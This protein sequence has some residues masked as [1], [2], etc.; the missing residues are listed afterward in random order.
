M[1]HDIWS[2]STGSNVNSG[3]AK[4][5]KNQNRKRDWQK[6]ANQLGVDA[7]SVDKSKYDNVVSSND[8][9]GGIN[10][11]NLRYDNST[12]TI[13][14]T[15]MNRTDISEIENL[16][17][18]SNQAV[19]SDGSIDTSKGYNSVNASTNTT[20]Y[21][22]N[23]LSGPDDSV[24]VIERG[25]DISTR[26][27]RQLLLSNRL[28]A[29]YQA[30]AI[31]SSLAKMQARNEVFQ[32][33]LINLQVK[34]FN[35]MN[36]ELKKANSFRISVQAKYYQ[37]S[38][39]TQNK[40]LSEVQT[41]NQL[42]RVGL[43]IKN[44]QR[45]DSAMKESLAQL[46][47]G[48][49]W[50]KYTK[51]G[52]VSA[53]KNMIDETGGPL[54]SSTLEMIRGM[55]GSVVGNLSGAGMAK[56]G[57]KYAVKSGLGFLFGSENAEKITQAFTNVGDT[58]EA[59]AEKWKD[60]GNILLRS[61]GK[62]FGS[63]EN[64]MA[65]FSS[66]A[67]YKNKGKTYKEKANFDQAAHEALTKVIPAQLSELL[68]A[69]TKRPA[70]Y[71]NYQTRDWTTREDFAKKI[72]KD[73]L[74]TVMKKASTKIEE[75]L[76]EMQ[77][78]EDEEIKNYF[79]NLK[80]MCTVNGKLNKNTYELVLRSARRYLERI[81]SK[82]RN[83]E[84]MNAVSLA[85]PTPQNVRRVLFGER[86]A[87]NNQMMDPSIA[88]QV[89]KLVYLMMNNPSEIS[90]EITEELKMVLSETAQEVK[91]VIKNQQEFVDSSVASVTMM[92]ARKKDN[93]V[94]TGHLFSGYGK[95]KQSSPGAEIDMI[96]KA[97]ASGGYS[98]ALS[99]AIKQLEKQKV[100]IDPD[101]RLMATASADPRIFLGMTKGTI[102]MHLDRAKRN[103]AR[104][105]KEMYDDDGAANYFYTA[106]EDGIAK[107]EELLK[108]NKFDDLK[109]LSEDDRNDMLRKL[110]GEKGDASNNYAKFDSLDPKDIKRNMDYMMSTKSGQQKAKVLTTAGIAGLTGVLAHKFAGFGPVGSTLAGATLASVALFKGD[111]DDKLAVLTTR[112]G[113]ELVDDG[114]GRT[115]REVLMQNLVR[116]ALPMGVA[117][118]AGIKTS[119]FIKANVRFGP[120][121]G[122]IMGFTVGSAVYGLSKLGFLKKIIGFVTKPFAKLG[123]IIDKK[124]FGGAVG[125]MMKPVTTF[126]KDKLGIGDN[127]KRYSNKELTQGAAE[128]ARANVGTL[129]EKDAKA[130]NSAID[131][132]SKCKSASEAEAWL[133]SHFPKGNIKNISTAVAMDMRVAGSTFRIP[134]EYQKRIIDIFT[135]N[136]W[137]GS[138]ASPRKLSVNGQVAGD[139]VPSVLAK[140]LET[141]FGQK[142][143]P[144]L[145]Y[146]SASAFITNGGVSSTFISSAL[147]NIPGFSVST[148]SLRNIDYFRTKEAF[149]VAN[150]GHKSENH[151]VLFY[152][153]NGKSIKCFDPM[154]QSS[155]MTM[156]IAVAMVKAKSGM[157]ITFNKSASK[158]TIIKQGAEA[159]TR[160][161][162]G[163]APESNMDIV[164]NARVSAARRLSPTGRLTSQQQERPLQVEVVTGNLESL[165]VVGAIDVEAY[166]AVNRENAK[167]GNKLISKFGQS[168]AKM[169]QT[170][171]KK[172]GRGKK[173]DKEQDVQMKREAMNTANLN[174]LANPK[175][176][177]EEKHG[178]GIFGK[179]LPL[180]AMLGPFLMKWFKGGP[181]WIFKVGLKNLLK[182][183]I[184]AGK[185]IGGG[186]KKLFKGVKSK[187]FGDASA[188]A[189]ESAAKNAGKEVAEEG[190]EEA[191]ENATKKSSKFVVN[192]VMKKTSKGAFEA[193]AYDK[194]KKAG[195]EELG[196]KGRI[197][198]SDYQNLTTLANKNS[199]SVARKAE[200]V[201][202]NSKNKKAAGE[203]FKKLT[204]QA[205]SN[206]VNEVI[207]NSADDVA[208]AAAEGATKEVSQEAAEETMKGVVTQTDNLL[209]K[210]MKK[211]L[212]KLEKLPFVG[213]FVKGIAGEVADTV[214]D[215]LI[216]STAEV[217]KEGAEAGAKAGAGT[218]K[219]ALAGVFGVGTVVNIAF[220]AWDIISAIN[221]VPKTFQLAKGQKPKSGMK[222]AAGVV[223]G[224]LSLVEAIVPFAGWALIPVRVFLQDKIIRV[225]YDKFFKPNPDKDGDGINDYTGE[226]IDP[227]NATD[228]EK[229][230]QKENMERMKKRKERLRP[231]I[232]KICG[233]ITGVVHGVLSIPLI[234]GALKLLK[235]IGLDI[236]AVAEGIAKI[237]RDE[238]DKAA[239]A[240]IDNYLEDNS[241][242]ES[243][244]LSAQKGRMALGKRLMRGAKEITAAVFAPATAI[245]AA[246]KGYNQAAPIIFKNE[247]PKFLER[248]SAGWFYAFYSQLK[249]ML[250]FPTGSAGGAT[251]AP[252]MDLIRILVEEKCVK[253]IYSIISALWNGVSSNVDAIT[254]EIKDLA[255]ASD[256]DIA[257]SERIK[258]RKKRRADQFKK[259]A[260]A[261]KNAMVKFRDNIYKIPIIGPL[262]KAW[263][264]KLDIQKVC[265]EL[266]ALT[267][268][269]LEEIKPEDIDS[270]L[271]ANGS[272]DEVEAILFGSGGGT[273]TKKGG[274]TEF[275]KKTGEVAKKAAGQIWNTI[276]LDIFK[277]NKLLPYVYGDKGAEN[278]TFG[279][280]FALWLVHMFLNFSSSALRLGGQDGEMLA[281]TF[282]LIFLKPFTIYIYNKFFAA[283][284][285]I[286][287]NGNLKQD[288]EDLS[289]KAMKEKKQE[290]KK[291][292]K[293]SKDKKGGQGTKGDTKDAA[294]NDQTN[295]MTSQVGERAKA[296]MSAL[297]LDSKIFGG[298]VLLDNK[299]NM[300]DI[301]GLTSE[302]QQAGASGGTPG[303]AGTAGSTDG[304][305]AGS[306]DASK[307]PKSEYELAG[308]K[309]SDGSPV[310][311]KTYAFYKWAKY[312]K[313][314]M[315]A[316]EFKKQYEPALSSQNPHIANY[317]AWEMVQV[318]DMWWKAHKKKG[319]AKKDKGWKNM[320]DGDLAWTYSAYRDGNI[321]GKPIGVPTIMSPRPKVPVMSTVSPAQLA[322]EAKQKANQPVL[323][324]QQTWYNKLTGLGSGEFADSSRDTSRIKPM[325]MGQ[326]FFSQGIFMKNHSIGGSNSASSGCALAVMKMIA[327]FL[328][329]NISNDQLYSSI[330]D[331]VGKDNGVLIGYFNSFGGQLCTEPAAITNA[332]LTSGSATAL[333]IHKGDYLHY[334]A[335]LNDKGR[336]LLGDPEADGFQE[337]TV[338]YLKSM[339]IIQASVFNAS[340]TDN[341]GLGEFIYGGR[342]VW[343]DLWNGAKNI[344]SGVGKTLGDA[345][346]GTKN[347]VG[348]VGKSIGNF[349]GGNKGSSAPHTA[350]K[351]PTRN[352]GFGE[353]AVGGMANGG[354]QASNPGDTKHQGTPTD[355]NAGGYN[356]S[357]YEIVG[358]GSSG[359]SSTGDNNSQGGTIT[360]GP[361]GSGL[362]WDSSSVV[363]NGGWK[364]TDLPTISGSGYRNVKPLIDALSNKF[365]IPPEAIGTMVSVESSFNP[366]ART[367]SYVGLAQI[368]NESYKGT[369]DDTFGKLKYNG[370]AYGL[371][372]PPVDL[373]EPK[374]NLTTGVV[375]MAHTSRVLAKR[376]VK[377][378]SYGTTHLAHMLPVTIDY[379][380]EPNK[381]LIDIPNV[382]RAHLNQNA[383]YATVNGKPGGES[384][385]VQGAINYFNEKGWAKYKAEAKGSGRFDKDTLTAT[386]EGTT[387]KK[388]K[389]EVNALMSNGKLTNIKVTGKPSD[390]EEGGNNYDYTGVSCAFG[391]GKE[392]GGGNF[393]EVP[394]IAVPQDSAAYQAAAILVD[395]VMRKRNDWYKKSR[396]KDGGHLGPLQSGSHCRLYVW[397]AIEHAFP[398]I[399]AG[400]LGEQNS[401]SVLPSIPYTRIS[402]KSK[403]QIG[404]II[405][406]EN[407]SSKDGKMHYHVCMY[408]GGLGGTMQGLTLPWCSDLL[409]KGP[410]P[411]NFSNSHYNSET[412]RAEL[413]RP[414]G[415]IGAVSNYSKAKANGSG[416][417]SANQ[418]TGGASTPGSG[419]QDGVQQGS[420][421]QGGKLRMRGGSVGGFVNPVTGEV[422][423]LEDAISKYHFKRENY[424][425]KAQGLAPLGAG[426]GTSP[427]GTVTEGVATMNTVA[428]GGVDP[429][430]SKIKDSK[431]G[432]PVLKAGT[433]KM[434]S[435]YVKA[436][437]A[438]YDK[439][440]YYNSGHNCG[441]GVRVGLKA[442]GV[443]SLTDAYAYKFG[444]GGEHVQKLLDAG[445]TLISN[446]SE[447]QAGDIMAT[448]KL[449]ERKPTGAK[450][451][452][453]IAICII[454][455]PG[456]EK[457]ITWVSDYRQPNAIPYSAV[458]ANPSTWDGCVALYRPTEFISGGKKQQ[459]GNTGDA[460]KYTPTNLN[461]KTFSTFNEDNL[462]KNA[463]T[464]I[465]RG[466]ETRQ[467][468][469]DA[470]KPRI[471]S[472]NTGVNIGA[473]GGIANGDGTGVSI[474]D[475]QY[476]LA[477]EMKKMNENMNDLIKLTNKSVDINSKQLDVQTQTAKTNEIIANKDFT[478]G[479]QINELISSGYKA[480]EKENDFKRLEEV[481]AK[482]KK[483]SGTPD[484]KS[485]Q[486]GKK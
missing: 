195:I 97:R 171:F 314:H 172:F 149:I 201:L 204:E 151:V 305:S 281:Q 277:I 114:S 24:K 55:L 142:V 451:G 64:G 137:I 231:I 146:E 17:A 405:R 232:E 459:T 51:K 467:K 125:E 256:A 34:S 371:P 184:W 132:L 481:M 157:F 53:L 160:I 476:L 230:Y 263:Q 105:R 158:K 365:H 92:G 181:R 236:A 14:S 87:N 406:M 255:N 212:P 169:K 276:T 458:R 343:G 138:G 367:G 394:A 81:S 272:M 170:F 225:V 346:N 308:I 474:G 286:D 13:T 74:T 141:T 100:E 309:A 326:R 372:D 282:Q 197:S 240:T 243:I 296:I 1:A 108:T 300:V 115:K 180:L 120:I 310:D 28:T 107:L 186:I 370:R 304:G 275:L 124:F 373:Y 22:E 433:A 31:T 274:V 65:S 410:A 299:G 5:L 311:T 307:A 376:G 483:E 383:K 445:Y 106:A 194:I 312:K 279:M 248:V 402:I 334:V 273:G 33:R 96:M 426:G 23:D 337:I 159:V 331:Y 89:A 269:R 302:A 428:G 228:E 361:V 191:V 412:A 75:A 118:A 321:M 434:D 52:M 176:K 430:I 478:N 254:G 264:K 392:I 6:V 369:R 424:I 62:A 461:P 209:T 380:N 408:V 182:G 318:H 316:D 119:E 409:Q 349:F 403:P 112:I 294:D 213:K 280:K 268:K 35:A 354:Q 154:N 259:A 396:E 42:L 262:A 218:A 175:P 198:V 113:D 350:A 469:A 163:V 420:T 103:I 102:K 391:W 413:Y 293:D 250:I 338:D 47:F 147:S 19:V 16:D 435:K 295:S 322:K 123:G 289:K 72:S 345:W 173:I 50:K 223:A 448:T 400:S 80:K 348:N 355:M 193:G 45:D 66:E 43:N 379:L 368:D 257:E 323:R 60:S 155:V 399:K 143:D 189:A 431:P 59:L 324:N 58:L 84:A 401:G 443:A 265:N 3:S 78:D 386:T 210:A 437:K 375:R 144:K 340:V 358:D 174:K 377:S 297:G 339:G 178:W 357:M 21:T 362:T 292:K 217:A 136:G 363:D 116:S 270:A 54:D 411:S 404:D 328:K 397:E 249:S 453:H 205:Q 161:T 94:V 48:S 465:S 364:Y 415:L 203:M 153:S 152:N 366:R 284:S 49:D 93:G 471:V 278:A 4:D 417:G 9:G 246:W 387:E 167:G 131:K 10:K 251:F 239:P 29:E 129:S 342:G 306:S 485:D 41:T 82:G 71:Y 436:G 68:A 242:T 390:I 327:V 185:K 385:T 219:G 332:I 46:V 266:I 36:N 237:I 301:P 150:V 432:L 317:N 414:N 454:G 61:I 202:K 441:V 110:Y 421:V 145:L 8:F 88:V 446:Q 40:I 135:K 30:K 63:K 468:F 188:E 484:T 214:K 356:G 221:K 235:K 57:A 267:D 38:I 183:G 463:Q 233:K 335:V 86:Y 126:V 122:P 472:A 398:E 378:T 439:Y 11:K 260:E 351:A 196:K 320:T 241:E 83:I 477:K 473:T 359:T 444:P 247:D 111:L 298:G 290:E 464:T 109:D 164:Q 208:K 329:R 460:D 56:M 319:D 360:G 27:Q 179:L 336:I 211:I 252:T 91:Q 12:K 479:N 121:L 442:A 165:G 148:G 98:G 456:V 244:L 222:V 90:G 261:I 344:A 486:A 207:A 457:G 253:W 32:T 238:F 156:P 69:T 190:A 330:K 79:D 200:F 162:Q 15:G 133:K 423:Q 206:V 26:N 44:G 245:A 192:D 139:C 395:F 325:S 7:T 128:R 67:Y 427:T 353:K 466:I 101:I 374:L 418:Q 187:L 271:E 140:I 475:P 462:S 288:I 76:K 347:F 216:K 39:E 452:F 341:Y 234:G 199:K 104:K 127:Q 447:V 37:N 482:W 168:V 95:G 20:V 449:N 215:E 381:K 134:D 419:G 287:E 18:N 393:K 303:D 177:K 455:V 480:K 85:P 25:N 117:T 77:N 422:I 388:G 224:I 258:H 470:F 416:N 226:L 2:T 440:P 166:S 227:A 438:S 384:N 352:I 425:R 382:T 429:T 283:D 333:M 220:A 99:A 73:P 291:A 70:Q 389:K 315:K 285:V 407:Q 450:Y 313:D 229:A 130:V